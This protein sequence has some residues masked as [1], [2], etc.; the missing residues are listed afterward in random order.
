M[1]PS[2]AIGRLFSQSWGFL[3]LLAAWQIWVLAAAY[4]PIVVVSPLRVAQDIA[5]HPASYAGPTLWTLGFAVCGM[6]S[7]MIAGLLLAIV[8]WWSE[9]F[10]SLVNPVALLLSSTPVVCLIPI[11]ARVFGYESRTEF[12]TVTIMTFFPS[13]VFASA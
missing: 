12:V 7:G 6:S 13:F 11:L 3:L 5:M 10:A 2:R 8:G 1:N 9:I 4:N